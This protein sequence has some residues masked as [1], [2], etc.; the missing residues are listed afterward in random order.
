MREG[1]H[2]AWAPSAIACG[3]RRGRV[4]VGPKDPPHQAAWASTA[5]DGAMRPYAP[6]GMAAHG[7]C[8][9]LD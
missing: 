2:G 9:K 7:S 6:K 5:N 4:L 8:F 1:G 3:D